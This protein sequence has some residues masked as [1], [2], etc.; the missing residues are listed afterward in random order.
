LLHYQKRKD[1][2]MLESIFQGECLTNLETIKIVVGRGEI[3]S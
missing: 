2:E 1:I 3:T